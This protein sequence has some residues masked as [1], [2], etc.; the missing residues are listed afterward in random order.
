MPSLA[1]FARIFCLTGIK[2]LGNQNTDLYSAVFRIQTR[3]TD[4]IR[5]ETH[6]RTIIE[7]DRALAEHK[8]PQA[9]SYLAPNSGFAE[10]YRGGLSVLALFT[11]KRM[12]KN[13]GGKGLLER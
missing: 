12:L 6:F 7:E 5:F 4:G 13:A 10:N 2:H 9:P 3:I 8:E 1:A 11:T